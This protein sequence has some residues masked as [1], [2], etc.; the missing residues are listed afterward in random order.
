MYYR[1]RPHWTSRVGGAVVN[2]AAR[3]AVSAARSYISGSS[4]P[5]SY[6]SRAG[7]RNSTRTQQQQRRTFFRARRPQSAPKRY[8]TVGIMGPR[9]KKPTKST[10]GKFL[11]GGVVE[12]VETGG[13]V[14]D[15]DCVYV[16]HSFGVAR[17][18]NQMCFAIV[19][20]LFVKA[21]HRIVSMNEISTTNSPG[22]DW[23]LAWRYRSNKGT[24]LVERT[25]IS[26]STYKDIAENL[27]ANIIDYINASATADDFEMYDIR[28]KQINSA[29]TMLQATLNFT[30]IMCDFD[31]S[32]A[33]ALQNQT[34]A[35]T[36]E[37]DAGNRM[38]VSNNPLGGKSYEGYG[39]GSGLK[40]INNSLTIAGN[41]LVAQKDRG[42]ITFTPNETNVTLEQ[43]NMYRRPPP[44]SSLERVRKCAAVGLKPGEIRNSYLR[45]KKTIQWNLMIKK[46]W[47]HLKE[48][49]LTTQFLPL[50]SFR[51][52]AFEKKCNTQTAESAIDVGFE[53]N[54]VYRVKLS[55]KW[56]ATTP[57][58][59]VL[60][61]V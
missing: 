30:D 35:D 10:P 2:Y 45:W 23:E 47:L 28:L 48:D 59:T 54:C 15:A 27:A 32:S 3:Q 44:A 29:A 61:P 40:L 6:R 31:C 9:F 5:P 8:H 41:L 7:S 22:T 53:L 13:S 56:K 17:I 4:R 16:G 33:L 18:F 46:L 52:F 49:N 58:I 57:Q 51:I 12:Y 19:Q 34:Q 1:K 39:T 11:K 25:I 14:T 42:S 55:T 20:K 36:T 26:G 21:G 37:V 60:A 38:E 50:C 43:K 24:P